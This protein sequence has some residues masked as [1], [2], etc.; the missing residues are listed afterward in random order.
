MELSKSRLVTKARR[1][2]HRLDRTEVEAAS[3]VERKEKMWQISE[4]VRLLFKSLEPVSILLFGVHL[5]Q[6]KMSQVRDQ[7]TSF[8]LIKKIMFFFAH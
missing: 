4:S 1:W 5:R 7:D 2:R 6:I 8:V 3:V